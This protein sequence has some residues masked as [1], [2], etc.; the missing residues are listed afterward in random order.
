[1]HVIIMPIATDDNADCDFTTCAGC[2][3]PIACN[4][5]A[6][7][8]IYDPSACDY[9]CHGCTDIEACNYDP[10]ATYDDGTF[11][12]YPQEGYDCECQQL[13]LGDVDQNGIISTADLL[14]F[15]GEYGTICDE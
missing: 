10:N 8:T 5:D 6:T 13:C 1:M 9:S 14:I 7:L 2:L 11:C 3:D 15:L 12:E 4:Y